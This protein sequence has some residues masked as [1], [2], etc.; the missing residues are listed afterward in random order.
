[1][2]T[3]QFFYIEH[4][5][6]ASCSDISVTRVGISL[7]NAKQYCERVIFP[8]FVSRN[9]DNLRRSS[10]ATAVQIVSMAKGG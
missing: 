5:S 9:R 10:G 6:L 3:F 4:R 1:M 8:V 7:R 2:R